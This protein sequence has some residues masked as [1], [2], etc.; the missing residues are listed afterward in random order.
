MGMKGV[1]VEISRELADEIQA[2]AEDA[3]V[4]LWRAIKRRD[5]T[6][7][8]EQQPIAQQSARERSKQRHQA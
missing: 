1:I 5:D 7:Q 2:S 6:R 3:T 8:A 4:M